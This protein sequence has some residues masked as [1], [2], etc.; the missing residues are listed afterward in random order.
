MSKARLSGAEIRELKQILARA[1]A[2]DLHFTKG[3]ITAFTCVDSSA[4]ADFIYHM[5]LGD[6]TSLADDI[7]DNTNFVD[8][9]DRLT[10]QTMDELYEYRYK[11]PPKTQFDVANFDQNFG[12][13]NPIANWAKGVHTGLSFC[14]GRAEAE[15]QVELVDVYQRLLAFA[16]ES[17]FVFIDA[18]VA[19]AVYDN[20]SWKEI[21]TLPEMMVQ[22]RRRLPSNIKELIEMAYILVTDGPDVEWG[23]DFSG[24][25]AGADDNMPPQPPE[26]F[27]SETLGIVDQ[28]L[29]ESE[30]ERDKKRRIQLLEQ[31][32]NLG[33]AQLGAD[34]FDD[35]VG[36]FWGLIETRPFMRALVNLAD[37]YRQAHMRDKS[38]VCYR[39]CLQLCPSDNLG[40]R[41]LLPA[42]LMEMGRYDETLSFIDEYS[43]ELS[44]SAFLAYSRAL[45][46]IAL[47]TKPAIINKALRQ[48]YDCNAGV[49]DLLLLEGD[50]PQPDSPY[51]AAGDSNEAIFYAVENRMLWRNL[52]GALAQLKGY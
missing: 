12:D 30:L 11:L 40:A 18:D 27:E 20:S 47:Q 16:C 33:R 14:L 2:V 44:Y 50:L 7:Y 3:L 29:Q 22:A 37:A 17:I 45:C 35:N 9:F 23:D 25:I 48:A 52:T 19:R 38:L 24:L 34:F 39:E 21:M 8:L 43:D 10:T 51:C 46:L 15:D 4:N 1:G 26:G 6:K 31:A 13:E 32:V 42:L 36:F 41:Y 49:P 28:L 5:L